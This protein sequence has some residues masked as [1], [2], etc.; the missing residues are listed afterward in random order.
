MDNIYF[1]QQH[2]YTIDFFKK[3][4]DNW[5]L[6]PVENFPHYS[7]LKSG[8][9]YDKYLRAS[10]RNPRI[11]KDYTL[12]TSMEKHQ[13]F[14]NLLHDIKINGC[15]DPITVVKSS[16]GKRFVVDGNHRSSICKY[17]GITPRYEIIPV[18]D[19]IQNII[20]NEKERYGT[21]NKVSYQPI[22]DDNNQIILYGRRNDLIDRH[23][24]MEKWLSFN[25]KVIADLGANLGSSLHLALRGGAKHVYHVEK[26][27]TLLTAAIRLAVLKG[28]NTIDFL[29]ADLSKE[30]II[31]K[32]KVDIV[33]CFSIHKYV[34]NDNLLSTSISR[35]LKNDGYL[36]FETHSKKEKIPKEFLRK[37]EVIGSHPLNTRSLHLLKKYE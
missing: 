7:F 34:E 26:S 18:K 37:F 6:I 4:F 5:N 27:T 10:W 28:V 8:D 21:Q 30:G 29:Q 32:E 12:Q 1:S 16:T 36:I 13:Q 19:Y 15:K 35:I 25:N 33:F 31:L 20:T 11:P 3:Y 22:Y 23:K 24:I 2:Y 14:N 17:L 9:M